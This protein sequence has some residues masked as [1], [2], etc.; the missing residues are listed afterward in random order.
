MSR[1]S[2]DGV[3]PCDGHQSIVNQSIKV[4]GIQSPHRNFMGNH[5][6]FGSTKFSYAAL[7]M[8]SDNAIMLGSRITKT[9]RP[10]HWTLQAPISIQP[11]LSI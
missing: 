10:M 2:N 1:C 5:A 4:G 9:F 3:H 8:A 6:G 11:R 7:T